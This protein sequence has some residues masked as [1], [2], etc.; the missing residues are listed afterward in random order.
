MDKEIAELR[1]KDS[2]TEPIELEKGVTANNF[3]KQFNKAVA[4]TEERNRKKNRQIENGIGWFYV[5]R[6]AS[7]RNELLKVGITDICPHKRAKQLRSTGVPFPYEVIF[8]V[9]TCFYKECESSV[10]T[11]LSDYRVS[12]EREFVSCPLDRIL[13]LLLK[14]GYLVNLNSADDDEVIVHPY[15]K[16]SY[17][18]LALWSEKDS[19]SFARLRVCEAIQ[20]TDDYYSHW[21]DYENYSWEGFETA[22]LNFIENQRIIKEQAILNIKA[23]LIHERSIKSNGIKSIGESLS[24]VNKKIKEAA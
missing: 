7:F 15:Y 10:L 2:I 17:D 9:K 8:A 3:S 4:L 20:M 11:K 22:L 1:K 5:L 6:N 21:G 12:D 14:E 24:G 18:Q 23:E 13:T 19:E 16:Q